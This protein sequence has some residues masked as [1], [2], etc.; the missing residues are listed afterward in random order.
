MVKGERFW[1]HS[2]WKERDIHIPV[3]QREKRVLGT[4]RD[5][6]TSGTS[7]TSTYIPYGKRERVRDTQIIRRAARPS[8]R[9][10][11]RPPSRRAETLTLEGT[12]QDIKESGHRSRR[13]PAH[14]GYNQFIKDA[15]RSQRAKRFSQ[16]KSDG[17][18]DWL[19]STDMQKCQQG[20]NPAYWEAS[21]AKNRKPWWQGS[22]P[23]MMRDPGHSPTS[24][25]IVS[26]VYSSYTCIYK[27]FYQ[28]VRQWYNSFNRVFSSYDVRIQYY[29]AFNR[30]RAVA[31]YYIHQGE[32][33][34][35]HGS[36]PMVF[37]YIMWPHWK[38]DN[39]PLLWYLENMSVLWGIKGYLKES[40]ES[41]KCF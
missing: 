9:D 32:C 6:I 7:G 16:P 13:P 28:C 35:R 17:K 39:L 34:Y 37:V 1:V 2:Q 40:K 14:K 23:P 25:M 41:V 19:F 22:V 5:P 31:Q 18:K 30:H 20:A 11:Q 29:N 38:E 8:Q 26:E 10:K 21:L 36:G 12:N 4:G 3:R 27:R 15:R 24:N 33:S